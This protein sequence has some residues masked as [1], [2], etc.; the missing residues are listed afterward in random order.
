MILRAAVEEAMRLWQQQ[1]DDGTLET[2]NIDSQF[3]TREIDDVDVCAHSRVLV[4][5]AK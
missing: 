4:L 3:Y 1:K 2:P 5:K